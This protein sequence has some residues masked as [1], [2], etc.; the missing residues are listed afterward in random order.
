MLVVRK[1]FTALF[2]SGETPVNGILGQYFLVSC[3]VFVYVT[4][5]IIINYN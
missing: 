3:I 1:P 4:T 2:H 5:A